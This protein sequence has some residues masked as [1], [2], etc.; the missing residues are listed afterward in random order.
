MSE[1]AVLVG[2]GRVGYGDIVELD[3]D[4]A[5]GGEAPAGNR[6]LAADLGVCRVKADLG[7]TLRLA[8]MSPS[9][10]SSTAALNSC[11]P[12][13]VLGISKSALK[14]P[15]TLVLTASLVSLSSKLSITSLLAGKPL[16][17]MVTLEPGE[18]DDGLTFMSGSTVKVKP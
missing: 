4:L 9:D 12:A 11:L 3:G 18:L 5:A 6:D 7:P 13:M 17:L 15:T 8:L 16:P 2:G 14:L 10:T 1:V